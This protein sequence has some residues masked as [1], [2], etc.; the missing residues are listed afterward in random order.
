MNRTYPIVRQK[1]PIWAEI[2]IV[3]LG[4]AGAI[5]F[6]TLYDRAMPS[7]S[8]DVTVSRAQAEGIAKDY[9]AQ[10]GYIPQDYKFALSFSGDSSPL[11]YLQRA[12]VQAVRKRRVLRL[13]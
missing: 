10:F 9:L 4:V 8:V 1:T 11:Y 3:I 13:P 5:T 2:L 12:L 7:A 6:F